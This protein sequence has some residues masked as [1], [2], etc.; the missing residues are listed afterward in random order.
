[1]TSRKGFIKWPLKGAYI[2]ARCLVACLLTA[3]LWFPDVGEAEEIVVEGGEV[4]WSAQIDSGWLGGNYPR[5]QELYQTVPHSHDMMLKLLEM[6][7][8]RD[9][10]L[11]YPQT[12][13]IFIADVR[14][15]DLAIS[16]PGQRRSFWQYRT[17]KIPE[18]TRSES[19]I[20]EAYFEQEEAFTL[21]GFAAYQGLFSTVRPN[22][23]QGFRCEWWVEID[24]NTYH[25]FSLAANA[26]VFWYR[27]REIVRFFQ[28]F[29]YGY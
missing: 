15:F 12:G 14:M 11:F 21:S 7:K 9:A 3:F 2:A 29:Q 1:M 27:F 18:E 23:Q 28:T 6:G 10:V 20:A 4:N 26:E 5:I 8:D 17:R 13:G 19:P 22:G 25:Y 16:D 24:D